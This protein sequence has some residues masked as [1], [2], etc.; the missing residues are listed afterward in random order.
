MTCVNMGNPHAVVFTDDVDIM[1]VAEVGAKI[2]HSPLF[3]ER[4]N[5]EFVAVLGE[6]ALRLRTWERGNGETQACGTGA[7]AAAVAARWK[8]AFAGGTRTLP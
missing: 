5:V 8:T 2:E 7:C 3:P 4:V 6:N 1:D